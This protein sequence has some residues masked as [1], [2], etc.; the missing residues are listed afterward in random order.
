[1]SQT[2]VPNSV[3]TANA[4]FYRSYSRKNQDNGKRETWE[5]TC[6]R[7]VN[8]IAKIGKL[9]NDE[10]QLVLDGMLSQT[11]MLSGR[12]LWIGGTEWSD[13]PENFYGAYNC[14][15]TQIVD[16]ESFGLLM[17]LA[18]QGCGT[19][20]LLEDKFIENL[21]VIKNKLTLNVVN[22]PGAY[23]FGKEDTI[24]SF[25]NDNEI[26]IVVG[27]S[28]K[29]WVDAYLRL[30][31]IATEVY[32]GDH[33]TVN[34]DIGNVRA[35]GKRLKGFGG[36][37]N[38]IK[39]G[40]MFLSVAKI[41]N[42][43]LGRKLTA[44]E[45]C[46]VIDEAAS[47]VV[48][49]NIRRCLPSFI[50]VDMADGTQKHIKDVEI[51]EIVKTPGGSRRV[52]D[53]FYQGE[54][55]CYQIVTRRGL[56]VEGTKNHKFAIRLATD[57][58]DYQ[59]L[60]VKEIQV[61]QRIMIDGASLEIT[62][63]QPS[64][65]FPTWDIEVEEEHCFFANGF[66]SHNSA[67]IK[68]AGKEDQEFAEC[69]DN[70]WQQD[71]NG[72]WNIDPDRDALRMS[73]HTRVYHTKPTLVEIQ[74]SITK[75]YYSGEGAIQYAPEA[76]A[77]GNADILK[78]NHMRSAFIKAYERGRGVD[79]LSAHMPFMGQEEIDHRMNRYGLNPCAEIIGTNFFCNLGEV[80]LNRL[81]HKDV[82]SQVRAFTSAALG[83][84]S[85][86][87]HEFTDQRYQ[88]S[89]E[90]DPIVA[91]S[92]TGLFDFFVQAFGLDWLK[93][94]EMGRPDNDY[95]KQIKKREKEYLSIW[96]ESVKMAVIYYCRKHNLKAPNRYTCTQP[97]GSKS[98]LTGASCGWHPPKAARYIRRITFGKNDPIALTYI[99]MGYTVVPSQSDKDENGNLLDD[100]FDPRCTEWLVEIPFEVSWA[101]IPGAD[102]ID[103]NK[104][105]A[106][107]QFDFYMQVQKH[108]STHT[109]SATIELRE[110]EIGSLSEAIYEA[111][112]N[113]E[114]YI[115]A[116]LL[117]RID[118]P[119]PRLPFETIDQETYQKLSE[120]VVS[121]RK[122]GDFH[123]ALMSHDN[124][125]TLPEGAAGCDSD[126][127]MMPLAK[128]A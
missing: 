7:T 118:A 42:R 93:W 69:K 20:S 90:L 101:N 109:T 66:L 95:G 65:V 84:C 60:P 120:Q 31:K 99:D 59:W 3:S 49:G 55:Q 119:Y 19:G 51:G 33:F 45:C 102:Q 87:H 57:P 85:L 10:K 48:A 53:K 89:R 22:S 71:E 54:Q 83:V 126:K 82:E 124:P 107:A 104:F 27:D 41:L 96:K 76:I 11:V 63:I 75:Q 56:A 44:T 123:T 38:P 110:D 92:F 47:C 12:W 14:N 100:P 80:H 72:S 106:T 64:A 6:D 78:N 62:E 24:W 91:V 108:Y 116:A 21:P 94:W 103:I 5:E 28:R 34:V 36:V 40:D 70:L 46:L 105:S 43:A 37:A 125:E 4:V 77:R 58:L 117:S 50:A 25:V 17:N 128:P 111:I 8:G 35:A 30:L 86:L 13:K 98:L 52:S 74:A 18:M 15:N 9:D 122:T 81:N 23:I 127:C 1:M 29:G 26:Q 97:A 79:Y 16:I 68:Q 2:Y 112:Q 61:G 115:S 88:E 73:N 67:G 121:R 32:I 113:D 39:L 114:G